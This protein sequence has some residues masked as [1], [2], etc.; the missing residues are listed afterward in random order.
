[1]AAFYSIWTMLQI[2][3]IILWPNILKFKKAHQ[4][5]NS[6][7]LFNYRPL[8]PTYPWKSINNHNT[9]QMQIKVSKILSI[10][11]HL[12]NKQS[13]ETI[14]IR[15]RLSFF[16]TNWMKFRRPALMKEGK[17]WLS[18]GSNSKLSTVRWANKETII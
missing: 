17:Y 10:P 6:D 16:R 5:P 13:W 14:Y 3:G 1:M 18:M 8:D 4:F 11:S 7:L 12:H 9:Y 15:N 2:V